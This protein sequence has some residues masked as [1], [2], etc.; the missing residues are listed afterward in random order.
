MERIKL[1]MQG[2]ARCAWRTLCRI[3]PEGWLRLGGIAVLLEVCVLL[4]ASSVPPTGVGEV[5]GEIHWYG[6][7]VNLG[8]AVCLKSRL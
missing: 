4:S 6:W 7:E 1:R 5:F 8:L 2:A 3:P